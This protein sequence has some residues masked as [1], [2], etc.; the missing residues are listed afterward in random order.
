[1]TFSFETRGEVA[2]VAFS[3]EGWPLHEE[4]LEVEPGVSSFIHDF[5]G[6]NYERTV[7]LEGFDADDTLLDT[8]R[9]RFTP[10]EGM[11]EDQPGFNHYIVEAI[12]D[13]E[14]YPK[15]ST[16]PY[17][18][19]YYGD[20]CG[21]MWGMIWGLW[22]LGEDLFPGGGDCFCTGHT[23]EIFFDAY[24]RWQDENAASVLDPF[25]ALEVDDVDRGAFYQHWQGY[26]VGDDASAA[27]AF[28]YA[29][30]GEKLP[31]SA[32][33]DAMT[34]DF[35]NISR[36]TGSGHSIIFVAWVRDDDEIVGLRYYGCNGSGD[37]RPDPDD[38]D[39][40]RGVSGPSFV[41]EYF[42][43]HGGTVLQSY[44]FIGHPYD[45]ADL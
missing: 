31:R 38:P 23:L 37:S 12:N 3:C 6:V 26:G 39:N 29:G 7:D 36:S 16:W 24:E 35:A 33:E 21:D 14:R 30:I 25:G 4:P 17:C 20:E 45:P 8:D 19:S 10:A 15:D 41:T 9:V 1:V 18:W 2:R 13:G 34:G 42:E 43:G 5:S 40:V 44:V 11:L 32:W 22:Y 27:D 28:E